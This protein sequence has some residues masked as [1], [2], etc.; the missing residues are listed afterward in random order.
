MLEERIMKKSYQDCIELITKAS[1]DYLSKEDAE[2]LLGQIDDLATKNAFNDAASIEAKVKAKL[3]SATESLKE[4]VLIEKRN[5]LINAAVEKKVLGYVGNFKNPA[6]GIKAYLG[7][8][9]TTTSG[10]RNSVDARGK[11]LTSKYAG[12]LINGLEK[13]GLMEHFTSGKMDL[14]IVKEMWELPEGQ[15]GVTKNREAQQIAKIIHDLQ[16]DL[17][18]RQNLAGSYIKLMPGYIVKQSHSSIAIRKAG[19]ES[20]KEQV[21]PLLNGEKTFKGMDP[22]EFLKEAYGGLAAGMHIKPATDASAGGDAALSGF[23]GPANLAKRLSQERVLQ[24]NSAEDWYKYNQVFGTKELREAVFQGFDRGAHSLSLLEG[25]GTNPEAMLERVKAALL[26]KDPDLANT[27]NG[28]YFN[29]IKNLTAEVTGKTKIPGGSITQAAIGRNWR[30]LNNI[31]KLGGAVLSSVTDIPF[32]AAAMRYQGRSLLDG[33]SN[34]FKSILTGRGD[35]EKQ[36]I[37]RL[38]GVGLEG[39]I[40][41]IHSRFSADDSLAGTA[42]KLQQR[43]FKLNLMSWWNDSQKTGIARMISHDLATNSNKA[44]DELRPE[45]VRTLRQYNIT[46]KEWDIIRET[47]WDAESG[48]KY[49][50]PDRLAEVDLERVKKAL[51]LPEGTSDAAALRQAEIYRNDIETSLQNFLVDSSDIAIPQPGA[52]ERAL[53]NQGSQTGTPTGEALRFFMQ[54]K[55]FPVTAFRKGIMRNVMAGEADNLTEALFKGKGDKLGLAHL[56]VM[57]TIFGY[58]AGLAKDTA[59]G[60]EPRDPTNPK[61]WQAAMLQGG[62]LGLYGDFLLGEFSRHGNSVLATA[63]GPSAAT[64]EQLFQVMTAIR[65]DKEAGAQALKVAVNNM[66]FINLFY[67]RAAFD[68]L[69]LYQFQ[70][71]VSPGYLSRLEQGIIDRNNQ[72]YYIPPADVIPYGGGDKIF[73]GVR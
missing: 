53:L 41:D 8:G 43:F 59:K 48:T 62:G 9:L 37:G 7:G 71:S 27:L 36:E 21:L 6:D 60:R 50:T 61:V 65:T 26:K 64:V 38:I 63:A 12:Q 25:L 34:A 4:S 72:E 14:D 51:D 57:T 15:I 24:F 52:Y 40:G 10:V 13:Q 54:F 28:E 70:E 17:V 55:S 16:N 32:Q 56:M 11:A 68:Y 73:E 33:Y 3:N 18:N 44:Y 22:E 47:A 23:K 42:A 67:T 19:Y 58:L 20:W 39:I 30:M 46:G 49:V 2:K 45:L 66:P 29:I 35:A 31:S 69:F 5:Q 1:K